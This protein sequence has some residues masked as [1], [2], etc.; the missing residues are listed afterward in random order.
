[1]SQEGRQDGYHQLFLSCLW[2][3]TPGGRLAKLLQ[4]AEDELSKI[5]GYRI[6]ITETSGAKLCH[7]L[8]NTNPWAGAMCGRRGCYPCGQGTE[9]VE[10]CKRRNIL[11]ESSCEECRQEHVKVNG[12]KAGK[13]KVDLSRQGVYVGETGR[14]L[15]E[16]SGEHFCDAEKM[17]EDSHIIKHWVQQHPNCQER[18]HFTFKV[19]SSFKDALTRQVSEAVRIEQRGLGVLNSKAEFSRC[20]LPRLTIDVEEWRRK[21]L[22]YEQAAKL[23]TETEGL[24]VMDNMLN[25]V[26]AFK[27]E[28]RKFSQDGDGRRKKKRKLEVLVN[29]GEKME[30]R[31]LQDD[32]DIQIEDM[33][34]EGMVSVDMTVSVASLQE[35]T[36]QRSMSEY[37]MPPGE[38]MAKQMVEQLMEKAWSKLEISIL[39]TA[40]AS[41]L[42][43]EEVLPRVLEV[44]ENNKVTKELLEDNAVMAEMDQEFCLVGEE[45]DH[46]PKQ[47]LRGV[48]R[49][50]IRKEDIPKPKKPT[51]KTLLAMAALDCRKLTNWVNKIEPVD[52]LVQKKRRLAES[53]K[54]S[55][56]INFLC[57]GLVNELIDR[58]Q[59]EAECSRVMMKLMDRAWNRVKLRGAWGWLK[60]DKALQRSIMAM[61][62]DED[63]EMR[64]QV[65]EERRRKRLER[66][67]ELELCWEAKKRSNLDNQVMEVDSCSQPQEDNLSELMRC[68]SLV[69]EMEEGRSD[70]LEWQEDH[71]GGAAILDNGRG[72]WQPIALNRWTGIRNQQDD[73]VESEVLEHAYLDFLGMDLGIGMNC[74]NT[75]GSG[76]SGQEESE[77]HEELD[78]ILDSI[79]PGF[80]R[81][82]EVQEMESGTSTDLCNS[83]AYYGGGTWWLDRWLSR[84]SAC[85]AIGNTLHDEP[86]KLLNKQTNWNIISVHIV[87][88][89]SQTG[90]Q[91]YQDTIKNNFNNISSPSAGTR[92]RR[93]R[94]R[95]G[96]WL[97][98]SGWRA[99][100][101]PWRSTTLVKS[102]LN[103]M[104]GALTMQDTNTYDKLQFLKPER[105]QEGLVSGGGSMSSTLPDESMEVDS[106]IKS[107]A[108]PQPKQEPEYSSIIA[109]KDTPGKE[110]H[111]PYINYILPG[112]ASTVSPGEVVA[113]GVGGQQ[114]QCQG[115]SCSGVVGVGDE[116][117]TGRTGLAEGK[118]GG[119]LHVE[120][121]GGVGDGGGEQ[122]ALVKARWLVLKHPL[123]GVSPGF[124]KSR[125]RSTN[126]RTVQSSIMNTS[127][128][129][130]SYTSKS[131]RGLKRGSG[132][133]MGGPVTDKKARLK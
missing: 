56:T 60:S 10:D 2:K 37:T 128:G 5:T 47:K 18:P 108:D 20:S 67:A 102:R 30:V 84:S 107:L 55:W 12:D 88:P 53:K 65:E 27:V 71:D 87:R 49:K 57:S 28:K 21:K 132:D 14:S 31:P 75:A 4:E 59:A 76:F 124:K 111:N 120:G 114:P 36:R 90:V 63:V 93:W 68:M 133:Q 116:A 121:A 110:L 35:D 39:G 131:E 6:R 85:G 101:S 130:L 58:I 86:S 115:A 54:E 79:K 3:Q 41:E 96:S 94:T 44:V 113:G 117:T 64:R 109:V 32:R 98:G 103:K 122:P 46:K 119:L 8:P 123:D 97:L 13:K 16:R 62:R 112:T 66:K 11:Y 82:Q 100:R 1:M 69:E 105:A 106:L 104:A 50:R 29:W 7:I 80:K 129:S 26:A 38:V 91:N 78:S 23:A 34:A 125:K 33:V 99:P 45:K 24:E 81:K 9:V 127:G 89:V 118:Q 15:H 43:E 51:R 73:I 126:D 74:D 22:E 92:K 17:A 40:F 25:E 52:P 61:I 95:A 19:V 72:S 70:W 77:A 83:L 42:M 48:P